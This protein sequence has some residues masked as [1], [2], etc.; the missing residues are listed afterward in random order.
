MKWQLADSIL[1]F[2]NLEPLYRFDPCYSLTTQ[3]YAFLQ[4]FV[5]G[6]FTNFLVST[7]EIIGAVTHLH[8]W[9][10]AAEHEDSLMIDSVLITDTHTNSL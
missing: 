9:S 3:C 10:D 5:P 4:G 6:K 2:F 7:S 1:I 8:V